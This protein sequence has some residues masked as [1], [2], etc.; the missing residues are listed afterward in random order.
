MPFTAVG[1]RPPMHALAIDGSTFGMYSNSAGIRTTMGR[2][3]A[4]DS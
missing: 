4:W 1:T 2:L 3:P